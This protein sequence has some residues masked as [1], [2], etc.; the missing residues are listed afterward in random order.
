MNKWPSYRLLHNKQLQGLWIETQA[1]ALRSAAGQGR[2]G[3]VS[4]GS[5]RPLGSA[6]LR[7]SVVPVQALMSAGISGLWA[8]YAVFFPRVLLTA[9][10]AWPPD[11]TVD[12]HFCR[13]SLSSLFNCIVL[14]AAESKVKDIDS[15]S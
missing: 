10:L 15:T 3:T 12:V 14:A 9:F 2:L 5:T 1:K 7:P 6:P 4:L 11:L 13:I 8:A